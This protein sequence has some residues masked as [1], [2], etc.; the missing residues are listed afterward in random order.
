MADF[1]AGLSGAQRLQLQSEMEAHSSGQDGFL[2]VATRKQ[3]HQ[4]QQQEQQQ[5]EQQQQQQ[6]QQHRQQQQQAQHLHKRAPWSESE[7]LGS[8]G[9]STSRSAS[10]VQRQQH[11]HTQQ[12]ELQYQQQQQL[13]EGRHLQQQQQQQQQLQQRLQAA[14]SGQ[15]Y[16]YEDGELRLLPSPPPP[17]PRQQQQQ[18]LLLNSNSNS[19]STGN[20]HHHPGSS[21]NASDS[22][23][24][25]HDPAA[26]TAPHTALLGHSSPGS[27]YDSLLS[28]EPTTEP[29]PLARPG[30]STPLQGSRVAPADFPSHHP[31]SHHLPPVT[32][33]ATAMATLHSSPGPASDGRRT[34]V[35][36]SGSG[37]AAA[38]PVRAARQQSTSPTTLVVPTSIPPSAPTATAA[39]S[40]SLNRFFPPP[41]TGQRGSGGGGGSSSFPALQ[42]PAASVPVSESAEEDNTMHIAVSAA[43][44]LFDFLGPPGDDYLLEPEA[45]GARATADVTHAPATQRHPNPSIPPSI[46]HSDMERHYIAPHGQHPSTTLTDPHQLQLQ[47]QLQLQTD[48]YGPGSFAALHASDTPAGRETQHTTSAHVRAAAAGGGSGLLQQSLRAALFEFESMHQA[49]CCPISHELFV[50]PV[51]AADGHTYERSAI[52]KWLAQKDTSPCTNEP[53]PSKRLVPNNLVRSLIQSHFLG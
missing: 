53:L 15:V 4:Q 18:R 34:R 31:S 11:Y 50:D 40:S 51:I 5:Q 32:A 13:Q 49:L 23:H 37:V 48:P 25:L 22:G 9:E 8:Q 44:S 41:Q 27:R 20:L 16:V 10:E 24:L 52:V 1:H 14:A 21:S 2:P 28:A 45:A 36:S 6:Q 7:D 35:G 47:L 39:P 33:T 3:R 26:P 38:A 17:P 30:V 43:E 46:Q 42:H 12:A 19:N 29:A